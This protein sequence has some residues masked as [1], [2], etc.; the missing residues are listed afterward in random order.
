[1]KIGK[2]FVFVVVTLSFLHFGPLII[3][4]EEDDRT[5]KEEPIIDQEEEMDVQESKKCEE[6]DE[7]DATENEESIADDPVDCKENESSSSEKGPDED[8]GEMDENTPEENP[9]PSPDEEVDE[10]LNE[11]EEDTNDTA[12]DIEENEPEGEVS[13]DAPV[14]DEEDAPEEDTKEKEK[15]TE[16]EDKKE[17]KAFS[18]A[19]TTSTGLKEGDKNSNVK[20]LKQQLAKLGFGG[21]NINETFGSFTTTRVKEFQRYYGLSVSGVADAKTMNKLNDILSS[22]IQQGKKH[23]DVISLK[24]KLIALG[25]GGMNLNQ[26]FGS[27]TE[28]R[29][30]QYQT[31]RKLKA[32][33]IADDV[34][35]SNMDALLSNSLKQG[36]NHQSV[37]IFK[38]NLKKLGFGGMNINKTYGS[39][40]TKRVKDFQNYYGL[41][42]TGNGDKETLEKLN[43]LVYRSLQ[44]GSKDKSVTSFKQKLATLG[45]SGM[46]INQT[47]GSYTTKRVK[48]FQSYYGLVT[49]GIADDRTLSKLDDILNGPYNVGKKNKETISLKNKLVLLGY[50][51][52][53]INETYGSF[54]STQVK[55]FQKDQKLQAN[56]IADDV[57][58]NKLEGLL[59]SSLKTGG[60]HKAVIS[61]KRNLASLGFGGMNI[62]QS[63]GSFT[64]KRVK[65][66]QQYYGLDTTGIG[67]S[68]TIDMLSQLV[69]SNLQEGKK[70]QEVIAFKRKLVE[71]GFGGMN[72]N[73]TFGSYTTKR[74]KELQAYYGLKA[75]GIGDE[76]TLEKMDGILNGPYNVGKKHQSVKALKEKLIKLQ[77]GGMNVNTTYGSF[78][79]TKV[80][81]FQSYY[82]LVQ[83]G[84]GDDRTLAKLD[85]ILTS[86]YNVGKKHN[87]V[88]AL[89][90]G[91]IQLGYG[92]MNVNTTYGAFTAQR[93]SE[94]QKDNGLKAH[95]IADEKTIAAINA[96]VKNL[97]KDKTDYTNYGLTLQ[98]AAA[99]QSGQQTDKYRNDP[100]YVSAGYL[101]L[102][103]NASINGTGVNIRTE[104]NTGSKIAYQATNGEVITIIK[105]VQ[106]T[107]VGG[108]TD[109][110]EFKNNS[111]KT[112]YVHSSLVAGKQAKV[113]ANVNVHAGQGTNHHIYGVLTKGQT[114]SIIS[115][116]TTWHQVSFGAWR[117]ATQEDIIAYM[118][119][120]NNDKFQHLRL[121]TSI[122]VSA[123]ELN[124][125]LVGKGILAGLGQAFIDGANKHNIN[126][127]Y[128]IAHASLETGNG[129]STLAKG[130]EVGKDKNG[131]FVLVT[132]SNRKNLTAI[133]TTYNMFGIGAVDSNALAGGAITAYQQGWFTPAT[134]ISGGAA[135]IGKDYIHNQ[136]Q[137]NT[138]YK[139]KWNPNM[140]SG[141]A[142]KQYATDI[143]WASK[144]I[145]QI[146]EIYELLDNPTYHFDIARY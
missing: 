62:N 78:T 39:Y 2:L 43:D 18:T 37:D 17:M 146:R 16:K 127:A 124:K 26:T 88:I 113:T 73:Q 3:H 110:I 142:W 59:T 98:Q 80:Q 53:N 63:Y 130:V 123:Q 74:V 6:L 21:M 126:E 42:A 56:G 7:Q 30:I 40:T 116:G 46:N 112:Y 137:Q 84:I 32:H 49:N 92:G 25:F 57:T 133:K 64:T 45:F 14:V 101:E 58:L 28:K 35:I 106:G 97:P 125:A 114:V 47:Y 77:F 141:Y 10:D 44:E 36:G 69:R 90:E 68:D 33:G 104:P 131:K 138:L 94:F 107:S 99:L 48:D 139:M 118:D 79:S 85:E 93:I 115:E 122:K 70:H 143:A 4:A 82:G 60:K 87:D 67:D 144:Q 103:G 52:M 22:P 119:P 100:A 27:F 34:T 121:D 91:L 86:P 134:A 23:K 11:G 12:T 38:R 50:G 61:F 55:K 8:Q 108:N 24:E 129:T 20:K 1:V 29:V 95:G 13:E 89:K 65:E 83:N 128:L 117:N 51:G 71:L 111:G 76:R 102:T 5:N 31:N 72:V 132:S 75:N 81:Q 15:A 19:A 54:T 120:N 140:A 109:W 136:H 41:K 96:A 9:N 66:F 145:S 135:W 105:T